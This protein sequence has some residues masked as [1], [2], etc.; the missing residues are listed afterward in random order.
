MTKESKLQNSIREL[1]ETNVMLSRLNSELQQ[2]NKEVSM[3]MIDWLIWLI[4]LTDWLMIDELIDDW[5][6]D[7][8]CWL[9]NLIELIDGLIDD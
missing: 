4:W 5:L 8:I 6:I 7:L 9:I 2:E 3:E 1:K